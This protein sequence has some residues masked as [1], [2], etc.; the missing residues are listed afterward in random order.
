MSDAERCPICDAGVLGPARYRARDRVTGEV[1]DLVRCTGCG[2]ARTDPLPAEMDR[3]YSS[4]Y[5]QYGRI[6]AAALRGL[7]RRRVA[8]WRRHLPD[9]GVALEIGAGQGWMLRALLE[10]GWS[11][12]GSERTYEAAATLRDVSGAP[13]FVGDLAAV[14]SGAAM[15]LLI[16]FHVL[17]HLPDP[18]VALQA[19]SER[20]A[21]GGV[22]I[23][24]I[25]NIASWQAMFARSS[26]LHLDVPRH[27]C[28]FTPRAIECALTRSGFRVIR[29]S[30]RSFEHDP[31][32]WTQAI[33][34]RFGFGDSSVLSLLSR[35]PFREQQPVNVLATALLFVPL[36][37]LGIVL[38]LASWTVGRG[39]VMEVWAVRA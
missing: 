14:R 2:F 3:Y 31:L 37:L 39:A 12:M 9:Q 33:L 19:A 10:A 1:F 7:Y 18:V 23:L 17:E 5:R 24:G 15:D 21:H 30:H 6:A 16:M 28:H 25:P 8:R 26:W 32:G 22:L 29:I 11:A 35:A 4:S 36:T 13:V 20:L 38:S 27:L 34:S